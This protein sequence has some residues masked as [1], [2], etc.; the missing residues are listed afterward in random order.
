MVTGTNDKVQ[1]K[2]NAFISAAYIMANQTRGINGGGDAHIRLQDYFYL[3]V[4]RG[5]SAVLL[6]KII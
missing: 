4:C 6:Q 3:A 2:G 1:M 5:R